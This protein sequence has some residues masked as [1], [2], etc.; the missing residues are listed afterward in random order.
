MTNAKAEAIAMR[1]EGMERNSSNVNAAKDLRAMLKAGRQPEAPTNPRKRT[2]PNEDSDSEP[3]TPD[4]VFN[5]SF[6]DEAA[7]FQNINVFSGEAVRGRFQR[8]VL[9]VQVWSATL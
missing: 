6:I 5:L 3:E 7:V 9:R 8:S 1:K 4:E 2:A